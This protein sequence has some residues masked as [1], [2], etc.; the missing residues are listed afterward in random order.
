MGEWIEPNISEKDALTARINKMELAY[1]LTREVYNKRSMSFK[2][3]LR[4]YNTVI[5]P[6]ALY[7]AECLT[8][9]KK[10][11]LEKLEAKERKIL[12]KILGPTKENGEYRRRHNQE[13]YTHI[14]KIT[15]TMRKRRIMFYGHLARM[16]KHRL[17]NK[18]FTYFQNKK[19]KGSWFTEVEKDMDEVGINQ[20][21]IQE[22]EP[23]K[24]KLKTL[25]SFQEKPKMKTGKQWTEERKEAHRRRMKEYWA[26]VKAKQLK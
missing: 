5:R 15:V 23:L 2:T 21:D 17:T 10:G 26:T 13:L 3:K 24:K 16:N 9:N 4:H 22:R 14:E 25:R 11:L 7:A 1:Q 12:R 18:I 20:D 8:M 19:T 6:E